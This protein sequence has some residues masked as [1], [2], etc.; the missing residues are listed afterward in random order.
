[1]H[2]SAYAVG[3]KENLLFGA[4]VELVLVGSGEALLDPHVHP[5]A[6]HPSQQL[7]GEGLRVFHATHLKVKP[8]EN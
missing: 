7:L 1:M 2:K 6:L 3:A 4:V 5:E 8:H